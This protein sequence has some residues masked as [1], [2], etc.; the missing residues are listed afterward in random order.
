MPAVICPPERRR[1]PLIEL[2]ASARSSTAMGP[3]FR[4]SFLS[5]GRRASSRDGGTGGGG[6][7]RSTRRPMTR[8]THGAGQCGPA[9]SF[10]APPAVENWGPPVANGEG[11]GAGVLCPRRRR[12][13]PGQDLLAV[14][15]APPPGI[16]ARA[17][18]PCCFFAGAGRTLRP[19]FPG[20]SPKP[21]AG[22]T[23]AVRPHVISKSVKRSRTIRGGAASAARFSCVQGARITAATRNRVMWAGQERRSR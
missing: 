21:R 19:R 2:L 17:T 23:V 4:F 6:G 9:H 8:Y 3:D 11:I 22:Q 10:N 16:R 12:S 14:L 5:G 7:P 1:P 20:P 13:G 15:V 18:P